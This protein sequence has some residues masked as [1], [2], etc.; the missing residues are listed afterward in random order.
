[1]DMHTPPLGN[2][3]AF[4]FP[5][6]VCSEPLPVRETKANKPYVRC[7][8]CGVQLFVRGDD[9]IRRFREA[10]RTADGKRVSDVIKPRTTEP[11]KAAPG[12][13]RKPPEVRE[14][15]ERAVEM[16]VARRQPLGALSVTGTRR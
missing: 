11:A 5:C 4:F 9:G 10:V 7:D 2:G 13:P 1:M 3:P 12:R 6:P 15:V 14:R 8:P 16:V